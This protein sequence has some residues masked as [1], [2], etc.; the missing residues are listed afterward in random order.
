M[1]AIDDYRSRIQT[2]SDRRQVSERLFIRI[3]NARLALGVTEAILAYLV[4]GRQLLSALWLAIPALAFAV[5]AVW[6]S[7]VIRQRTVADRALSF[8]AR[9]L[10]RV[11]DKWVGTGSPGDR[12]RD[13]SHVYADDL[14]LF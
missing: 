10:A 12:F 9:G 4:F 3:G 7:R 14:D 1:A 5:L 8:Y 11:D 13:G 6:H 2:W